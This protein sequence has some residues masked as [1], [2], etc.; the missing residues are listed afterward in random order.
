MIRG[1]LQTLVQAGGGGVCGPR[2]PPEALGYIPF[3]LSPVSSA[4]PV[5]NCTLYSCINLQQ[6]VGIGR[7]KIY[8]KDTI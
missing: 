2:L 8:K 4:F 1:N 3:S 5:I 6:N 7:K